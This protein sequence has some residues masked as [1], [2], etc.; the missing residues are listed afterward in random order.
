[1]D[2]PRVYSVTSAQQPLSVDQAWRYKRYLL[3][4]SIR[5]VCFVACII[6]SGWLRW[7][8]FVG[9]LLLPWFAVVLANA[10][11]EN[12]AGAADSLQHSPWE[13]EQ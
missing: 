1:M 5:V 7:T 11:R 8:F 10:G 4:M 13:L 2:E 12:A 6:A 3:S 9:A